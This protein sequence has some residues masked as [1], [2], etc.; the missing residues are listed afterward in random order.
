[1]NNVPGLP[2]CPP[3]MSE[4]RYLAL[5]F[6]KICTSCGKAAKL[7]M[8]TVLRVRL[9]SPCRK[10]CL[11]P[12]N[13]VPAGIMPYIPFSGK[14]APTARRSNAYSLREDVPGL[15][16]EY[17]N[18]KRLND[19]QALRAWAEEKREVIS[20]RLK[21]A[22]LLGEFLDTMESARLLEI[23]TTKAERQ[24]EI[25]RRLEDLGWTWQDMDFS[26]YGCNE[27]EWLQLVSQPRPLT[28]RVWSNIKS[29][30]VSLLEANRERRLQRERIQR[31]NARRV[32][33]GE[34]LSAIRKR[35]IFTAQIP[36][37]HP[38]ASLL[39]SMP[40]N[41]T[42]EP[43][44]PELSYALDCPIVL[45]LYNSDMTVPEMEAKFEQHRGEIET[46]IAEW[47][48]RIQTHCSK[49][50]RQGPKTTKKILRSSLTTSDNKPNPFAKLSDDLKL[51]LRADSFFNTPGVLITERPCT[52]GTV[53]RSEGLLGTQSFAWATPKAPP[54]LDGI[55]W[56]SE[57]NRIAR[58]LLASIGTPNA[59]YL[60]MTNK[61]I[62]ACG[63]CHDTEN[64]T[65]EGM[66]YHYIQHQRSYNLV[67]E[68]TAK[69][70]SKAGVTFNNAHDLNLRTKLPL[71]QRSAAQMSDEFD[72]YECKVCADT[73]ILED[74]ISSEVKLEEHL[75]IVH[76]I[77][78]PIPDEHYVAHIIEEEDSEL[79]YLSPDTFYEIHGYDP[80]YG[81]YGHRRYGHHYGFP[82]LDYDDDDYDYGDGDPYDVFAE[83]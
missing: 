40:V 52:Y 22:H 80:P 19:T 69:A 66:V 30:L 23:G 17:E 1:M 4:P 25:Q 28:E 11:I 18:K 74:V 37:Q 82:W 24:Q 67:Q 60:E 73:M 81:G 9:C 41:V 12:W 34:L 75:L 47:Q 26:E 70:L 57:A 68:N 45:D 43:P 31:D 27:R 59:S 16:E 35:G 6:S 7:E 53:L 10:T 58:A 54:S 20:N 32:Q 78:E 13:T 50:A 65:W 55:S 15:V 51:L 36:A 76:G 29:K 14:I 46:F 44:F 2:D 79:D 33:L 21:H 62:Y 38:A 49:L 77:T 8:D 3:D 42:Y 39:G 56:N 72:Q 5:V 63:R 48:A 64:K 83:W 61:S 71:I